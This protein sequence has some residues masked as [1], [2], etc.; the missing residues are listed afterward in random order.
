MKH[1]SK[2]NLLVGGEASPA[3]LEIDGVVLRGVDDLHDIRPIILKKSPL[4][5]DSIHSQQSMSN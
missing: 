3:E 1:A 5:W 4:H 2:H